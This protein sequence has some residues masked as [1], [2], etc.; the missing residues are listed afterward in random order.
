MTFITRYLGL[1]DY[2]DAWQRMRAFT[3]TRDAQTPDEIW[4][5]EHPAVFT[6]GQAGSAAHIL[7]PGDIPVIQTDR[8][9]QVTYHG[10]G[11]LVIYILFDL[12]RLNIS[13]R[14]LVTLLEQAVIDVLAEYNITAYGDRKAP[15]VYVEGA[16]I[17][18]IGLRVRHGCTYHG[19][20]FN[21]NMDLAPYSRI[22]PCGFTNLPVT[23]T[24]DLGGPRDV[25]SAGELFVTHF[26][27][28][29]L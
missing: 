23:Q 6:Q 10:P 25:N 14:K 7:N 11:Q 1:I 19:I 8:G 9:G 5:L 2:Q 16:K 12:K 17:C 22:N 26:K 24:A 21:I 18:A 4:L 3:D 28:V 20:A 29:L 13:I 15:G 27:T